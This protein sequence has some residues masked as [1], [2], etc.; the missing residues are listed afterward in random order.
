MHFW[1]QHCGYG[2]QQIANLIE[3][4]VTICMSANQLTKLLLTR[5][6]CRVTRKTP[7]NTNLTIKWHKNTELLSQK[8]QKEGHLQRGFADIGY[9][10]GCQEVSYLLTLVSWC[11]WV[12]IGAFRRPIWALLL[13]LR[14]IWSAW[15]PHKTSKIH[16]FSHLIE[17]IWAILR[18]IKLL[19][20]LKS[21]WFGLGFLKSASF[22][23]ISV[24]PCC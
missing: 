13:D 21:D 6:L 12:I 5:W 20:F 17:S 22:C 8:H 23:C 16:H 9:P 4:R 2:I 15:N 7:K 18:F 14:L 24:F 19:V 11:H 10:R 1:D 3:L